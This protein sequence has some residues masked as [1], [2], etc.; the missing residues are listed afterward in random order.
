[1]HKV[2]LIYHLLQLSAPETSTRK[3]S[4]QIKLEPIRGFSIDE[5]VTLRKKS[6]GKTPNPPPI[7]AFKLNKALFIRQPEV[8]GL[9]HVEGAAHKGEKSHG[10]AEDQEEREELIIPENTHLLASVSLHIC[11]T[12]PCT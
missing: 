10:A 8:G 6:R 4:D 12:L 1:M 9:H 5:S 2:N 7:T 3:G 11:D